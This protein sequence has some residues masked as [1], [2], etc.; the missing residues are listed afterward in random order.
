MHAGMH[1]LKMDMGL[2]AWS[3]SR[4]YFRGMAEKTDKGLTLTIKNYP[5]AVDGLELWA[6]LESWVQN[7][8]DI[9][10]QNDQAVKDDEE[11][12]K[13]W[14]EIKEIGHGDHR[15]AKWWGTMKTKE[16]LKQAL[17]TIIWV[18][19]G[20]HA[21]VNFGQYAYAGFMPNS[22]SV[23]RR[24]I[25]ETVGNAQDLQ[26]LKAG[27]ERFLLSSLSTRFEATTVM[28]TALLLSHHIE[29]EFLGE[30]TNEN[31]TSDARAISAFC[32]F[33]RALKQVEAN[34]DARNQD[35][36]LHKNRHGPAQMPYK[37]LFPSSQQGL[38]HQGV[39]NSVAI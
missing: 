32:E 27:P 19:S 13:W 36:S 9:Y 4:N 16:E 21:A 31:W 3:F 26:E 24:S 23:G 10:Y 20:H 18:A 29:E 11:V 34:I 37:L 8:L 28:G 5:Y 39:P 1:T 2:I 6:A 25:P 7:Y 30:A 22:P 33:G 12:K 35:P 17:V 14:N 15:E 38:T